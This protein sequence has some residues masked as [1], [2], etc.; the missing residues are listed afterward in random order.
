VAIE[1]K[2]IVSKEIMPSIV[3]LLWPDQTLRVWILMTQPNWCHR[4]VEIGIQRMLR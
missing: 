4:L 3:A 2:V 1:D